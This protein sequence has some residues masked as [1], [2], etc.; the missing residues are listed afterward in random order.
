M[1]T[2]PLAA[3]TLLLVFAIAPL[4]LGQT[5][6][7]KPKKGA[8]TSDSAS[9][10]AS[11]SAPAA[12]AEAEAAPSA[13]PSESASATTSVPEPAP[14][15]NSWD[16]NN[17]FEDSKETYYFVGAR[18]RG[19]VIPQF[20][21]NLFVDDGATVYSNTIGAELDMRKEG[22]STI[23]FIT[24]T[25]YSL[26]NTLFLQK[27]KSSDAG[28][29]TMVSSSL[30]AIFLGLDELWSVPLEPTHKVDYE[31]G[32]GVGL[33]FVFGDLVNN[34]V[35]NNGG[36][37]NGAIKAQDGN[38]YAPC[39]NTGQ[40][41]GCNIGD[42]TNA[43]IAKVNQYQEPNW[44]NGGAVPVLYARISLQFLGIRYKPVKQMEMRIGAG[45]A[46]TE[47]FWFQISGDYGLE[48]KK[49]E[50]IKAETTGPSIERF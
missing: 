13:A 26:G 39:Q 18:Y 49:E 10:S 11:A 15:T 12:S 9:A 32:F 46:L 19:T 8:D 42:H 38:Y 30:K 1:K 29:I 17:T 43:T 40:G 3:T 16:S 6:A 36:P 35:Y 20:I 31:F 23:P 34:W 37:G 24:Y 5:K 27:G 14:E 44:F 7:K 4:A 47:G 22:H 48:K 21:E 25:D 33:G 45:F 50:P 2:R 28:N 41:F